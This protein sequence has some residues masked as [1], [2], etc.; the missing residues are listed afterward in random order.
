METPWGDARRLSERAPRPG[1]G[2][3]AEKVARNR[4]ERLHAATVA[5]IADRGYEATTVAHLCQIAC[6][7]RTTFYG[8]FDSKHDCFLAT[9]DEIT[10]LAHRTAARAFAGEGTWEQRLEAALAAIIGTIASFPE[11]A[12][13]CYVDAYTA[14][15]DAIARAQASF[16]AF[17]QMA[18]ETIAESP[19]RAGLPPEVV[20]AVLGGIH[21]VIEDHLREGREAE[22]PRRASAL[23]RW[24]LSYKTPAAPLTRPRRRSRSPG[25]PRR[26]ELDADE[27]ILR[28]TAEQVAE[29]GYVATTVADIAGAASVSLTT[30]YANFDSKEDAFLAALEQ[31]RAQ[32]FAVV[33]PAFQRASTWEQSVWTS[34][35]ALFSFLAVETAWAGV[36]AEV[37]SAGPRASAHA[38]ETMRM[39]GEL[40]A[41]GEQLADERVPGVTR[42]AV[43]GA[44][45]TLAV[46]EVRRGHA[47]RLPELLPIATFVALAPYVGADEAA[48]AANSEGVRR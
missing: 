40:L 32:G 20:R 43:G 5:A 14:G 47:E 41:S 8:Q 46:D 10:R 1:A 9:I 16:A 31:G 42:A 22:L 21:V 34:L 39:F 15:P 33:L 27:R 29:Q 37:R 19:E 6:V 35:R 18:A 45:Y 2:W 7:S 26:I 3:S 4:R 11:T 12:R 13:L 48:A 44:L 38:Q 25:T 23:C 17:D 24:A 36:A 28:A 30:F